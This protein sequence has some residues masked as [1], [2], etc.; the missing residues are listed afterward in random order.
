MAK[1]AAND[2]PADD[3]DD[4]L[5]V[6]ETVT[7]AESDEPAVDNFD[8]LVAEVAEEPELTPEQKR[9]AELEA[10]LA[11]HDED[12]LAEIE[13]T[14]DQKR[15]LELEAL[16]AER[17]LDKSVREA[18]R[19]DVGMSVAPGAGKKILFHFK[20]DGLLVLGNI[21]LRGQEVEIEV[22]S[23]AY[24]RTR[25]SDGSSWLDILDDDNAQIDKW[26]DHYVG[27]GPFVPRR[28]E[29]FEDEVAKDDRKRKRRPIV[30][31]N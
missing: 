11:A 29:V 4:L 7:P 18:E 9:I 28:G 24:E 23:R 12:E 31:S 15:I 22:G 25:G 27:S 21:W 14:P 8:D 19:A 20:K 2:T 1:R 6:D 30:L 16:L 26:G 10:A 5:D 17:E 13:L 3:F